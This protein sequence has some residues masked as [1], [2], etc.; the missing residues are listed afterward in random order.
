MKEQE[1]Y[2]KKIRELQNYPVDWSA[3]HRKHFKQLKSMITNFSKGQ[4]QITELVETFIA[5]TYWELKTVIELSDLFLIINKINVRIQ[6]TKLILKSAYRDEYE[7]L[8]YKISMSCCCEDCLYRGHSDD[9]VAKYKCIDPLY[10]ELPKLCERFDILKKEMYEYRIKSS[11]YK[12]ERN[13]QYDEI[14]KIVDKQK[15]TMDKKLQYK[16]ILMIGRQKDPT[17]RIFLLEIGGNTHRSML[18]TCWDIVFGYLKAFDLEQVLISD[19]EFK[20]ISD[21]GQEFESSQLH[22]IILPDQP[23]HIPENAY[24]DFIVSSRQKHMNYFSRFI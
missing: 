17:V 3:T 4:N 10:D 14:E 6:S 7:E 23:T 12:S 15:L 21:R 11:K 18:P 2:E 8:L 24:M 1:V 13:I 20:Q 19:Q 5:E 22:V 9:F 16:H